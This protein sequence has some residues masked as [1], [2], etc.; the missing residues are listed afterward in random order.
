VWVSLQ[1]QN[2]ADI[3]EV[4]RGFEKSVSPGKS[5]GNNHLF[6]SNRLDFRHWIIIIIIND[7][8]L[9]DKT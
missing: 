5:S 2:T 8:L 7:F 9:I 6:Y 3:A 4:R 1:K